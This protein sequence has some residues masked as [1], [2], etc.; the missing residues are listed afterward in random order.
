M[1]MSALLLASFPQFLP[2]RTTPEAI[3]AR[4]RNDV[5]VKAL[6][7]GVKLPSAL[8]LE[9]EDIAPGVVIGLLGETQETGGVYLDVGW[10][11]YLGHGGYYTGVG[12]TIM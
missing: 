12:G 2:Y 6:K 8:F 10:G 11:G 4:A 1:W 5:S 3:D 9:E 7:Q